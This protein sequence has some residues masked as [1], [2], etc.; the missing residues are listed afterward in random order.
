MQLVTD[1]LGQDHLPLGGYSGGEAA[2][3]QVRPRVR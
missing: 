2:R 3:R 1:R